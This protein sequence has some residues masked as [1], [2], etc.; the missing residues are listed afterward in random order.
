LAK[1]VP[2]LDL[3]LIN[4]ENYYDEEAAYEEEEEHE[5]Y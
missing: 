2:P 1:N 5:D 3:E 4:D